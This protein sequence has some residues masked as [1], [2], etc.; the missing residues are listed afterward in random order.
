MNNK[1]PLSRRDVVKRIGLISSISMMPVGSALAKVITPYQVEGPFHPVD[2]QADTDLD[3]TII[4]GNSESAEG[5]QILVQGRATDADGQ[6]LVDALVDIWQANTHG[7]YSH[8]KDKNTAPLDSNFQGWG[9]IRTDD[10]GRYRFKTIEPG[11]YP[12]SFLGED[13]WR[14]KHIHFKVSIP[15]AVELVTQMYFA[16][17][18]LIAQDLEVAKVPEEH[19]SLLISKP[20]IDEQT[21]L[22]IYQFDMI[23]AEA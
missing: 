15:G 7:R 13:G 16:G 17:D 14:C 10:Q 18:P 5:K 19:R 20:T 4:N 9:L 6:P 2:D 22:P 3:L 1:K 21:G 8:P 23:L 11:P 12:L